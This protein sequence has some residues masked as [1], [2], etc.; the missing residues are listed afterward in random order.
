[1]ARSQFEEGLFTHKSLILGWMKDYALSSEVY[2]HDLSGIMHTGQLGD[3][4]APQFLKTDGSR[5]LRCNLAVIEGAT[6]DGVD[7]S[8]HASNNSAHHAPVTISDSSTIDL[9]LG[10]VGG[11]QLSASV[12]QSGLDHGSIGGL[13]D[14][15]HA[16]YYNAARH[17]LALHTGLGL[18]PDTRQVISGNGL[19]GGGDLSAD[20][21]LVIGAGTGISVGVDDVGIDLAANLTWSGNHIFQGGL[22]TRHLLPEQ[23]DT[24]DLGSST[25]LWRKGWLSELDSVLFAQNTITL[26]GGWFVVGKGEGSL[27]EDVGSADTSI[28]F[29]QSMTTGHFVVLRSSL[30]VEYVQVG[31]LVSGTT[32]NVTRNLDGSGANDW[33]AGTVFLVLGVSG[34]GRIEL[35]AYDT[36]RMSILEQ[37]ATYNAQTERVRIG[38]LAAWQGAGFTGY[39]IAIGNY[40]GGESLIYSPSGGLE[41]RGTIK[42]DDGYLQNLTVQGLLSLNTSGELRAG[43]TTNGLRFGYLT[44]GYYLRGVGGGTTQVEIKAADGKLYAGGGAVILDEDGINLLAKVEY[45][46]Y[47]V[48]YEGSTIKY[49]VSNSIVGEISCLNYGS[50]TFYS[51]SLNIRKKFNGHKSVDCLS[52][53]YHDGNA[54]TA[55]IS[56]GRLSQFTDYDYIHI[57][58]G[59]IQI[60]GQIFAD[61]NIT[62]DGGLKSH[63]NSTDYTGYIFVPLTSPLTSTSWD[64]DA[65]SAAGKT[66]IDL[67]AVFGVP[68]G[69]KAVNIKV[70]MR[71]SGSAAGSGGIVLGPNATAWEGKGVQV[72]GIRN[73]AI[74]DFDLVVP[75]NANGDIYYQTFTS[76]AG[77]LDVWLQ[78]WGYWI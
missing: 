32:Y 55:S 69:V 23:T 74:M 47:P 30:Q 50:G 9:S 52:L 15:D 58:G 66:L 18:V 43:N 63:K 65:R 33:A 25:L 49:F 36:T 26:L 20:R 61:G 37:G 7:L 64:G 22:S 24:Y 3:S 45:S 2:K 53:D 4:Q 41:V 76:G 46:P 12:I 40:S 13:A 11:Q 67:S 75:C 16:Q 14:D 38:D 8:E 71:D 35:N 29:G 60:T 42:A 34:D 19:S 28:D 54:V 17:T 56:I 39:G 77:T 48:L 78:I 51:E 72:S 31:S 10:G 1:M 27:P 59:T 6:L 73:D 5:Q 57:D 62:Y 44:D 68:A 21:T 70:S